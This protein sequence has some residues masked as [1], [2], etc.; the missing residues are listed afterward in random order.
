MADN[1]KE[2]YEYAIRFYITTM[3]IP[4]HQLAEKLLAEAK[5]EIDDRADVVLVRRTVGEP[6]VIE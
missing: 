5:A 3:C 6:E 2:R 1:T 4:S